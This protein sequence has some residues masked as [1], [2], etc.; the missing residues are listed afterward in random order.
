VRDDDDERL[1]YLFMP[2]F[3]AFQQ[4]SESYARPSTNESAPLLGRFRAVPDGH[5]GSGRRNSVGDLLYGSIFGA[6]GEE[7][8]HDGEYGWWWARWRAVR[9]LWIVP[10][11]GAVAGAVERWWCRWL[12][13]IV[14]P[15]AIVSIPSEKITESSPWSFH[16]WD[17]RLTR[18]S[19]L[20]LGV[21]CRSPNTLSLRRRMVLEIHPDIVCPA[22]ERHE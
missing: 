18:R 4:G 9:D 10:T 13:L 5:R 11:R 15:A 14:M 2:S 8:T 22:T 3:F 7:E 20:W 1:R 12:V 16:A 19:R 6:F 17:E 21:R